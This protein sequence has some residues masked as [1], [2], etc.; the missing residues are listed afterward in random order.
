MSLI[1][2]A[3]SSPDLKAFPLHLCHCRSSGSAPSL[4]NLP[5][6]GRVGRFAPNG[7]TVCFVPLRSTN[8]TD[9]PDSRIS[10]GALVVLSVGLCQ[11]RKDR[12]LPHQPLCVRLLP[13][14]TGLPP[15]A[16]V[17]SFRLCFA[18]AKTVPKHHRPTHILPLEH[19]LIC[20]LI[21]RPKDSSQVVSI[22]KECIL[23]L[24]PPDAFIE[25]VKFCNLLYDIYL[26]YGMDVLKTCNQL[27]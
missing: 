23:R 27:A 3:F 18:D 24:S 26:L 5:R 21:S 9:S 14:P 7:E 8:P 1:L 15:M 4:P 16:F 6:A 2:P 10:V 11:S 25:Q 17:A 12:Y 19:H 22:A 13:R 20:N